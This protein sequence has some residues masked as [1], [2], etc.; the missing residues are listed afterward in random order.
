M[1]FSCVEDA[2]I[3]FWLIAKKTKCSECVFVSGCVRAGFIMNSRLMEQLQQKTESILCCLQAVDI[4][5]K[6]FLPLL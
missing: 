2:Q 3:A 6:A 5:G 4:L 1:Q